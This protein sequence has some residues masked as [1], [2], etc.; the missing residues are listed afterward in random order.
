M[1]PGKQTDSAKPFRKV[2][3]ALAGN[4]NSGKTSLFNALTGARQHVGN[5]PGVTVEKI[6][7]H[8][9][10]LNHAI[11]LVDL[12]GI[13]SL[14][15]F[16]LEETIARSF[17]VTERPDVVVNVVDATNLE[18][19]LYL[20]VQ[21]LEMGVRVVVV[22]N[23]MDELDSLGI[24]LN[25]ETI[26]KRLECPVVE[27]VASK[28]KGL[29]QL[30]QRIIEAVENPWPIP[31]VTYQ[32]ELGQEIDTLIPIVETFD[33]IPFHAQFAAMKLLENDEDVESLFRNKPDSETLFARVNRSIHRLE[34][35]TGYP[36]QVLIGDR[37]YG[38][39]SGVTK[40]ATVSKP[41]IDRITLTEKIDTVVTH[42]V[43]GIPVFLFSMYL[44]FFM[45]FTLGEI[46]MGWIEQI[47]A[48]I[49]G[50]I[51]TWWH[52]DRMSILR[53]LLLDG[54]ISGVGG[55]IV[56]L[57]NIVLLFLGIAFLEDTGYMSRIAF[58][59]D[60]MMMK[61][62]LHGRS[63]IPLIIG[64][65]CT[66]PAIMATRTIRSEKTRLTT[67]MILPLMSCG[68]R[69][70]IYLLIIP[71][72]FPVHL[73]ATL[74]W[75]LYLIGIVLA[76]FIAR[77]LRKT[78]FRG[79]AEPFVMEL[80]PYRLPSVRSLLIHMW[81]RS[82]MYL[83]KASTVI[84]AVSILLWALLSF[85]SK[86]S[87]EVDSL[88]MSGVMI[89]D[90]DVE[91]Q[92]AAERLEYSFAGRIGMW[93]EPAIRPMGFD[94]KIGTSFI[95]AIAAKEL[96][97]AQ[98]GIVYSLGS[99]MEHNDAL[100]STLRDHYSPLT[101]FCIALFAL[102]ALPCSATFA[103]TRRESGSWKWAVLQWAGLT[104]IGWIVTT[105]VY[106]IGSRLF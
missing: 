3:V 37:R 10:F 91:R 20:T 22:L 69:L 19:N 80:P 55:V 8:V 66:V 42:R 89:S 17:L 100:R 103:V 81:E 78:L 84:L 23:M 14:T 62:G 57:P 76:L 34:L 12:P 58:I 73:R 5:Y 36:P 49:S 68:A 26:S 53:S 52:P 16:S 87:F 102:I 35:V 97:V 64:F 28:G 44:I 27:T 96:F 38:F 48:W 63:F 77:I 47:L 6:E 65:G 72:F 70:T 40:E 99:G 30:L 45:T 74:L 83:K 98:I 31:N 33:G 71:A 1:N 104:A 46:P 106:Q 43:L 7:G 88:R 54:V 24:V 61:I 29:E 105:L 59:M 90:E 50:W 56:F 82:W 9:T 93:I 4:P 2:L 18:R 15:S 101:G 94:W 92:R 95:G 25:T 32:S 51:G 86:S 39:A 60:K 79:D 75:T 67:M 13:Y 11:R 21:L 85:P 41:L